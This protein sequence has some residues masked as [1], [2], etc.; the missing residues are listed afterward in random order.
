M[1]KNEAKEEEKK[2][3]GK[4]K[5]YNSGTWPELFVNN[6]SYKTTHESLKKYF[7]KYGEVESTKIVYDKESG[8]PKG[9]GF[10]KFCDSN[11]AA[12]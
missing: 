4:K 10:C 11:N 8:R 7:S 2:E 3:K 6:L 1:V 9:V 12:K 5:P